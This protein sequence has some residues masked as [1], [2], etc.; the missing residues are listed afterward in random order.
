[1]SFLKRVNWINLLK[2]L[3]L[4]SF[5]CF[6]LCPLTSCGQS[7]HE[8]SLKCSQGYWLSNKKWDQDKWFIEVNSVVGK[9]NDVLF[10]V[11]SVTNNL[12]FTYK[13]G[14]Q[15]DEKQINE[16]C[17]L[18]TDKNFK[19]QFNLNWIVDPTQEFRISFDLILTAKDGNNT[20]TIDFYIRVV[21][22]N[23]TDI[24]TIFSDL[25]PIENKGYIRAD[26]LLDEMKDIYK[27]VHQDVFDSISFVNLNT[28][29]FSIVTDPFSDFY[30][31][32]IDIYNLKALYRCILH[33]SSGRDYYLFNVNTL[34]SNDLTTELNIDTTS[35][36][37]PKSLVTQID[38]WSINELEIGDYFINGFKNL[39]SFYSN[40]E[41]GFNNFFVSSLVTSIK[42]YF[43]YKN[44]N[45]RDLKLTHASSTNLRTIGDM[46]LSVNEDKFNCDVDLSDFSALSDIGNDFLF[47]DKSFNGKIKLPNQLQNIGTN[48]LFQCEAFSQTLVIP[49]R[50]NYI[51]DVF[52]F[53]TYNFGRNN[54][55]LDFSNV[56]SDKWIFDDIDPKEH[57]L[58]SFASNDNECFAYIEGFGIK[59]SNRIDKGKFS[60][61]FVDRDKNPYR[62]IKYL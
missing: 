62:K 46:F 3:F 14:A 18:S 7:T 27:D 11:D 31:G 19:N 61:Y 4:P 38:Y 57:F 51:A 9:R 24:A 33:T 47:L 17:K 48:F 22:S 60:S 25:K 2:K 29:G 12:T 39:T 55:Y 21:D 53:N 23:M 59:L 34:Y 28:K 43:F 13:F 30:F 36:I 58:S 8:I 40:G 6:S 10:Y 52:M 54:N 44:P 5:V 45:L 16:Y 35:E 1:M 49:A 15:D 50:I 37:L 32:H 41:T 26:Y 56:I 42:N 20:K